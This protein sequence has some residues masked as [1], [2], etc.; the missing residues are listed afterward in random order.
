MG[1][2]QPTRATIMD[3]NKKAISKDEQVASEVSAISTA[4]VGAVAH[5]AEGIKAL[6]HLVVGAI[7]GRLSRHLSESFESLLKAGSIDNNYFEQ[8]FVQNQFLLVTSQLNAKVI[9]E[10]R[11]KCLINIFINSAEASS[12]E[13]SGLRIQALMAIMVKL[14]TTDIF[15]LSNINELR[16]KTNNNNSAPAYDVNAS[17]WVN[18]I[19]KVSHLEVS[20]MVLAT[21]EKLVEYKLLSGRHATDKSGVEVNNNYRLTEMGIRLC[22]LM[23]DPKTNVENK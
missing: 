17:S 2:S 6:N 23:S 7:Q 8:P 19:L 1:R 9:D 18:L 11:V 12:D 10:N 4:I 16:N 14:D 15:I 3:G 13:I 5:P 21:E 22:E 20:E